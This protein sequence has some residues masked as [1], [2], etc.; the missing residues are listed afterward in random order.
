MD[1]D[2]PPVSEEALLGLWD[3]VLDSVHKR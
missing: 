2:A 3:A 1:P